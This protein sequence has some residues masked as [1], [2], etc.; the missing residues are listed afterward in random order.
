MGKSKNQ[1]LAELYA[2]RA[3]LSTISLEKD[4]LVKSE[5]NVKKD[6]EAINAQTAEINNTNSNIS[7]EQRIIIDLQK[8]MT[9]LKKADSSDVVGSYVGMGAEGGFIGGFIAAFI[10]SFVWEVVLEKPGNRYL[11]FFIAWMIIGVIGTLIGGLMGIPAQKD[12]SSKAESIYQNQINIYKSQ[13]NNLQNQI[14]KYQKRIDE[15]SVKKETLENS[16][17]KQ[18]SIYNDV[19]TIIINTSNVLYDSLVKKFNDTLDCRD[20]KNIDLIIFYYETGRADT[21]KEALFQVDRQRQ[22]DALIKAVK[23]ASNNICQTIERSI[24]ELRV[25][26]HNCFNTLSIQLANQH[27]EQM[28]VLTNINSSLSDLKKLAININDSIVEGDEKIE[29]IVSS[30]LKE[31]TTQQAL[32]NAF[33]NKINVDSTRLVDD[34]NYVIYYKTP[35]YIN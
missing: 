16:Y 28:R 25:D 8:Q 12:A 11:V 6:Y 27:N 21:I 35:S 3:G 4:K 10:V 23:D 17:T 31:I 2:I 1:I 33:I 26:M 29:E 34:V 9:N 22:N 24:N 15:V 7:E 13:I 14:N 30:N 20:W 5:K 19:K 18:L 32:S